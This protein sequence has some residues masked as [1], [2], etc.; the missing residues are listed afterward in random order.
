L[1]RSGK[2]FGAVGAAPIG[3]QALDLDAMSGVKAEGLVESVEDAGNFFVGQETS[4]G[5]AGVIVDGDMQAFHAGTWIAAGAIA[6]GPDA[7]LGEAA[8]LLDVKVKEF[9]GL[10]TFVT[11]DGRFGRFEAREAVEVMAAQDTREGGFGDRQH[12]HNLS[13]GAALAAQGQNAGFELRAGLSR[14]MMRDR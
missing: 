6:G 5:E 4:E 2:E 14:L 9:T 7:G 8:Q 12:G 10:G 13:V 1:A 3:E 11:L